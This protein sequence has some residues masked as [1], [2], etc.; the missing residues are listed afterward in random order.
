VRAADRAKLLDPEL[1]KPSRAA[2]MMRPLGYLVLA[3]A[4]TLL[5]IAY[6]A[7]SALILG[8]ATGV[9]PKKPGVEFEWW[10][11]YAGALVIGWMV[12]LFTPGVIAQAFL[13]WAMTARAFDRRFEHER[14]ASFQSW[15]P[16]V[17]LVAPLRETPWTRLLMKVD[18]FAWGNDWRLLLTAVGFGIVLMAGVL[19]L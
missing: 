3:L 16:K 7:V 15:G 9:I 17:T 1:E 18:R 11:P 6:L 12:L 8:L 14:L 4:L 13:S 10:L 5:G 2:V 19:L